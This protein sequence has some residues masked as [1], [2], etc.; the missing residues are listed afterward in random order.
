MNSRVVDVRKRLKVDGTFAACIKCRVADAGNGNWC[1]EFLVREEVFRFT[2]HGFGAGCVVDPGFGSGDFCF[3]GTDG[4]HSFDVDVVDFGFRGCCVDDW[5]FIVE[6]LLL[7]SLRSLR[8]LEL[9][10]FK[11]VGSGIAFGG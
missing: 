2:A 4:V 1:W 11:I 9:L 7:R 5:R 6:G 8:L 10:E 3:V